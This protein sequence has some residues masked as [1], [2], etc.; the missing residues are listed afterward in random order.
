MALPGINCDFSIDS[1]MRC[2]GMV[3][4]QIKIQ[5]DFLFILCLQAVTSGMLRA[6]VTTGDI[7]GTVRHPGGAVIPNATA[8]LTKNTLIQSSTCQRY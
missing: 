2:G 5:S 4:P 6:K 8:T 7:P 3:Q 1:V